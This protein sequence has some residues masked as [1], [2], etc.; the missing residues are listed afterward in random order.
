MG[1]HLKAVTGMQFKAVPWQI[2][3]LSRDKM[4]QK[5]TNQALFGAV[6]TPSTRQDRAAHLPFAFTMAYSFQNV[7]NHICV[8]L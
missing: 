3:T 4:L 5:N 6:T 1:T 8:I 2:T 7:I